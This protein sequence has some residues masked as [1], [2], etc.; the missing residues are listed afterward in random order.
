MPCATNYIASGTMVAV[1][2]SDGTWGRKAAATG[3]CK[4]G[5]WWVGRLRVPMAK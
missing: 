2:K 5:G 4:R 3:Q 1:C